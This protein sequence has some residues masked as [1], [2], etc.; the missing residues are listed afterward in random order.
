MDEQLL[1]ACKG[2]PERSKGDQMVV[3]GVVRSRAKK[4]KPKSHSSEP[5]AAGGSLKVKPL[6]VL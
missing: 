3:V 5:S 2:L 4:S 1:K 6:L